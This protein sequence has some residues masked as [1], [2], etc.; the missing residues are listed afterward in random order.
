MILSGVSG[1]V[2]AEGT[3]S[4]TI[5][6][7]ESVE[8]GTFV[9]RRGDTVLS[10]GDEIS[11]GD[12]ITFESTPADGYAQLSGTESGDVIVSASIIDTEDFMEHVS[13]TE[14]SDLSQSENGYYGR[15]DGLYATF[16]VSTSSKTITATAESTATGPCIAAFDWAVNQGF[17]NYGKFILRF[18]INN[19]L[20]IERNFTETAN[21]YESILSE[22][23]EFEGTGANKLIWEFSKTERG[24]W[25]DSDGRIVYLGRV[26]TTG[27]T[28]TPEPPVFSALYGVAVSPAENGSVV[29]SDDYA[30]GGATITVN[31]IP[32]EGYYCSKLTV[33]DS[34]G[35]ELDTKRTGSNSCEFTM[36][37]SSVTVAAEFSPVVY[38]STKEE[39]LAF[40]A[41]ASQNAT[42]EAV[43]TSD[44]DLGGESIDPIQPSSTLIYDSATIPERGFFGVIDGGYHKISNFTITASAT[45]V[46]AG[47][48]GTLSGTIKNLTIENAAYTYPN[49]DGRFGALCGQVLIGGLIE[50]CFVYNSRVDASN[51][52][53]GAVAGCNYGGIIRNC[54]EFGNTVTA[55]GRAG[56]LVGDNRNDTSSLIGTVVN[57]YSDSS[58]VGTQAGTVTNCAGSIP[59]IL[60]MA[61]LLNT[62]NTT[63]EHSGFWSVTSS[64]I[65]PATEANPS[66]YMLIA[67]QENK[68]DTVYYA[69]AGTSLTFEGNKFDS[70]T[71]DG[72]VISRDA[73]GNFTFVVKAD[74]ATQIQ[75]DYSSYSITFET[76]GGTINSGNLTSYTPA[77]AITLPTD[78]TLDN[79]VFR[80]WY[81]NGEFSGSAVT[82]LPIG[83]TGDKTYYAK[84]LR[85]YNVTLQL[86]GG[87]LNGDNITSYIEGEG[88]SLPVAPTKDNYVFEGWFED[89]EFTTSAVT[90]I[91]A[92]DTGD[93]V[94]YAKFVL[95]SDYVKEL[96]VLTDD[97]GIITAISGDWSL[98]PADTTAGT[99]EKFRS[100]KI[101]G[102]DSTSLNFSVVVPAGE[103]YEVSFDYLVSSEHSF[104]EF[105]VILDGTTLLEASG[106][107][108]TD[109]VAYD[110]SEGSHTVTF[111]YTKDSTVDRYDDRAEVSNIVFKK[112]MLSIT[113]VD[114]SAQTATIK[115]PSA[116]TGTLFFAA[117]TEDG[118][119]LISLDI[120]K[121]CE[122]SA[123]SA[124]YAPSA[125]LPTDGASTIE[126]MLWQS[127]ESML[128]L[129]GS[130]SGN[131]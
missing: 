95:I 114:V 80:G 76:N 83:T 98:V 127:A 31:T 23:V 62:E 5:V 19:V 87:V 14:M 26:V 112:S 8:N 3:Q 116:T 72:T 110:I 65:I 60:Q 74:D 53:G 28:Y 61:Y 24:T 111:S 59:S 119:R 90:E 37:D 13:A 124:S 67:Y 55:Y 1:I 33:T 51:R 109:S 121:E 73:D 122:I 15:T 77:E 96:Q 11:L 49:I 79:Y 103:T 41:A 107:N 88:A 84:F 126:V 68:L 29:L 108:V 46:T 104:D 106:N 58:V 113:N 2:F 125:S 71:Y 130:N 30:T 57:C 100:K 34:G 118:K 47:L 94:F 9:A 45:N 4:F 56:H 85:V 44:I 12:K 120:N 75:L 115:A 123:G 22:K 128:P 81:E 6:L 99:P 50:N 64:N 86:N 39:L 97:D 54:A 42:M 91:S 92:T 16:S 40:I 36:V 52:I 27:T 17:T 48:V 7:P 10:N 38:I 70:V 89:A 129:C 21:P 105:Y 131:I 43:L 18:Y 63:A 66:V 69:K 102:S 101:A 78:V 32:A 25:S 93:K 35:A 20:K 117:Y 82:S